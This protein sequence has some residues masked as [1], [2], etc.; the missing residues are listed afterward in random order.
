M[1]TIIF[2][3]FNPPDHALSAGGQRFGSLLK[4]KF[5]EAQNITLHILIPVDVA[6]IEDEYLT[7]LGTECVQQPMDIVIL[8][9]PLT[10]GKVF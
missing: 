1:L 7:I 4:Q 2:V 10:C 3:Q 8:E 5:P 6:Y 9:A